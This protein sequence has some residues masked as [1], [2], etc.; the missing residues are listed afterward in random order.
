MTNRD[1]KIDSQ[2]IA[3]QLLTRKA[4]VIAEELEQNYFGWD[5]KGPNEA[6]KI[7]GPY[8]E[9]AGLKTGIVT[10]FLYYIMKQLEELQTF[11]NKEE[12]TA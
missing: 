5:I 10:D 9:A 7:M 8:Y 2:I 1:I 3:L 4:K 6:W 11:V 12:T